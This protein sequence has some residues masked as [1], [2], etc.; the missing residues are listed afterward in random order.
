M[1]KIFIISFLLITSSAF[2]QSS[3]TWPEG[4]QMAISLSFDDARESQV[5]IG[6][7]LLNQF[8]VKATFYVVP[9]SVKK[10][11]DGWKNAVKSGHEIGNHTLTHPCTGNF[12]WSRK[13]ALEDYSKRV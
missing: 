12:S 6:T 3:F 4:K 8:E 2:S 11:L 7:D 13:N 5:L 1:R 10:Q 9:S